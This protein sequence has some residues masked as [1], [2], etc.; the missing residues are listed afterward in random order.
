MRWFGSNN[1]NKH[2]RT[3]P[4]LRAPHGI[5]MERYEIDADAAIAVLKRASSDLNIKV[6][7][8]AAILVTTRQLPHTIKP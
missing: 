3:G 2:W 6:R 4:S 1:S 5:L 8:V 7:E